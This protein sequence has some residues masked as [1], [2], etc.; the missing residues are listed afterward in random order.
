LLKGGKLCY[1]LL[2]FIAKVGLLSK[3]AETRARYITDD[4]VDGAEKL[5]SRRGGIN[6]V[7]IKRGDAKPL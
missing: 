1:R 2:G 3:N 6:T 4:L 7:Y 5:L